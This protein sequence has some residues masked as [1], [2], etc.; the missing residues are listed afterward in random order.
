VKIPAGVRNGARIRLA[1]RGEPGPPGSP[2][3]DLFVVVDVEPHRFFGR[4]GDDLT[5]RLPVTYAE[6]TL[7]ANVEVPTLNGAVKLK[8]PAGTP[9]GKTFRI[10]GRG[11]PKA[12]GG[13]GDLLA[14]VEVNVPKKIS[15]GEKELLRQ[16]QEARGDSPRSELGVN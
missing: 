9:T 7:G 8:V 2:P 14:T 15:R 1:S 12:R 3:G 16:L 4:R 13:H 11:A 5:V 10:K 6:A